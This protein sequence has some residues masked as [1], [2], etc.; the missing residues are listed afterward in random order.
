MK[1]SKKSLFII[2][3]LLGTLGLFSMINFDSNATIAPEKN[4][5]NLS[6]KLD[7]SSV[8]W[9][10][11]F[12]NVSTESIGTSDYA[13]IAVDS[14]ENVHVVWEDQ[15]DHDGQGDMDIYYK[16]WNA[17]TRTWT[18]TEDLSSESTAL[19]AKPSIA[20]DGS[21]NVHVVWED[22]TDDDGQGDRDIYYK[23][24]NVTTGAW[25]TTFNVSTESTAL[26]EKPSVA[27][28]GSENV[29]VVWEDNTNDDL[30]GDADIYYKHW[31]ATTLAWT[32]TFNV[33]TESTGNSAKPS[34]AVDSS[35]KVH[36]VWQDFTDHDGEADWDIYYKLYNPI[37]DYW[38]TTFNVSTESTTHSVESSIAVDS[39]GI[40]HVVWEDNTDHDGE[41][42]KDI[43]Y[44]RWN[45]TSRD[46]TKFETVSSTS[47]GHSYYPSI[48]SGSSMNIHVVWYDSTDHDGEVDNDI[49]YK[50]FDALWKQWTIFEDITPDNAGSASYPS[51]AAEST[52]NAHVAYRS[53]G[54]DIHYKRGNTRSDSDG[55]GLSDWE[56]VMTYGTDPYKIDTDDDNYLDKYEID[57]G[58]DPL[59]PNDYPGTSSS[60]IIYNIDEDDD[61]C[62]DDDD[63][64]VS[65]GTIIIAGSVIGVGVGLGVI[66]LATQL[67]KKRR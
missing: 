29:H 53:A 25:T 2:A 30:E 22:L 45:V 41:G 67:I 18:T 66:G 24:W 61:D 12:V 44:S 6:M 58:T 62:D 21:E 40:A 14:S 59:D 1:T 20:V 42:D 5:I 35:G 52:G 46:F 54:Y 33:S 3:V 56:E 65:T 37:T 57:C 4:L 36:I 64:E 47:T 28:D 13:S 63:D 11:S 23:R 60:T 31:N 55:D 7:T 19:A 43:Y 15:T 9:R 16:R 32:T 49:Y 48:T 51:I 34:I 17:T 39:T 50:R 38:T 10:Y 26:A 27:V 8:E